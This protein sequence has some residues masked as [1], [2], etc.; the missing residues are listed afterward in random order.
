MTGKV[1][2]KGEGPMAVHTR[3]GWVL[4]GPVQGVL[5]QNTAC[6][7]LSTHALMVDDYVQEE[8]DRTLDKT[9]KSFWDLESFG[10]RE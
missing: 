4:S 6:N 1:I 10:I 3:L 7:L 5:S 9:L 2:S 8:S